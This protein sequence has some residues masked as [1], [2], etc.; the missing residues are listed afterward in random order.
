MGR[1]GEKSQ[2]YFFSIYGETW[3]VPLQTA[4]ELL[5]GLSEY[6]VQDNL[7]G[8]FNQLLWTKGEGFQDQAC[9][10]ILENPHTENVIS[11]V[12]QLVC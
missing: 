11:Y 3:I 5:E 2:H 6:T 8:F 12:V 9:S 4:T 7:E 10:F 1:G